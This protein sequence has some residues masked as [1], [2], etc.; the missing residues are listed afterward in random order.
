MDPFCDDDPSIIEPSTC[1]HF[2]VLD[3]YY[4]DD[5]EEEIDFNL[6]KNVDEEIFFSQDENGAG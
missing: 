5:E 4:S 1:N 2:T 6:E 3:C